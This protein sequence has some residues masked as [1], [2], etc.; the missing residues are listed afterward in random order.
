MICRLYYTGSLTKP[1]FRVI[2]AP[3]DGF[4]INGGVKINW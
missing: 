4:V 3:V 1:E 2:Y